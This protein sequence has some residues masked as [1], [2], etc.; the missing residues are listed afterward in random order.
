M[1][2]SDS[3]CMASKGLSMQAIYA[4]LVVCH[5][6]LCLVTCAACT[7]GEDVGQICMRIPFASL[8]VSVQGFCFQLCMCLASIGGVCVDASLV[9]SHCLAASIPEL[10][11]A[12]SCMSLQSWKHTFWT[13]SDCVSNSSS[14]QLLSRVYSWQLM[15]ELLTIIQKCISMSAFFF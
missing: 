15:A 8:T 10:S 13:A 9:Y 7:S 14:K 12:Q 6:G 3:R 2:D 1:H 4:A 11:V 5:D